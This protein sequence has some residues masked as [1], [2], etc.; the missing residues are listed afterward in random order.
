M[1][2]WKL[3]CPIGELGLVFPNSQGGVQDYGHLLRRKF[4]PLLISARVCDQVG[5]TA[6]GEPIMKARYGFHAFRHAAASAWIKSRIDLKRLQVWM[7][8]EDIQLTLDTY[9]HLLVD[10]EGDARLI[11]A[12]SSHLLG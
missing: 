5:E 3:R 4:Q 1:K 7:G 6:K 11:A 9:G 10:A 12:A 2:A 8:H